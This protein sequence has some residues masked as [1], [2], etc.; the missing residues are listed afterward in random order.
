LDPKYFSYLFQTRQFISLLDAISVGIRQGRNIPFESF[1]NLLIPVPETTDQARIVQLQA[2]NL[3][4]INLLMKSVDP[5]KELKASLIASTVMGDLEVKQR[6][7][8][9]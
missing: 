9:A 5:L 8:S 1:A 6:K 7:A 4:K 3:V 2:N